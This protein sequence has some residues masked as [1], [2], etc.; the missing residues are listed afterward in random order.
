MKK[1]NKAYSQA[2]IGFIDPSAEVNHTLGLV[3]QLSGFGIWVFDESNRR[4]LTVSNEYAEIFGR[5]VDEIRNLFSHWED[6]LQLV[7]PDDRERYLKKIDA[8]H[9]TVDYRILRPDG[10][11]RHVHEVAQCLVDDDG[12]PTTSYGSIQDITH[13]K[14]VEDAL[15]ESEQRFDVLANNIPAVIYQCKNDERYTTLYVND[16]IEDLCGYTK[17]EFY[18]D[19]ICTAELTHPDFFDTSR[20]DKALANR[21][22]F[23]I[24][25]QLRHKDG[26]WRWVEDVGIGIYDGNELIKIEGTLFDITERKNRESSR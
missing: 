26:S 24:E 21:E 15:R 2:D 8:L 19:T 18:A 13:L 6:D 3:A 11:I 10:E 7:H 23:Q 12:K 20:V 22:P 16:A 9:Y 4:M 25:Y 17:E 1:D 14:Q 5:S